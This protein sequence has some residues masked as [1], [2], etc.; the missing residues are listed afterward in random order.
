MQTEATSS[1]SKPEVRGLSIARLTGIVLI[2]HCTELICLGMAWPP[3]MY[4][5]LFVFFSALLTP[6]MLVVALVTLLIVLFINVRGFSLIRLRKQVQ[7]LVIFGAI[8]VYFVVMPGF[9]MN[10]LLTDIGMRAS[11]M[12]SGGMDNLQQWAQEVV[13]KPSEQITDKKHDTLK[14]EVMSKQARR[15][16]VQYV[17]IY[18]ENGIKYVSFTYGSGFHHWGF[19]V[20]PPELRLESDERQQIYKWQP[21]IYGYHEIQ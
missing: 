20:G 8:S 14:P 16:A 1:I 9:I 12:L 17:S 13:Q 5:G 7:Y 21:G 10:N 11:V 4:A 6:L 3:L 2:I 19:R 18:D 15:L